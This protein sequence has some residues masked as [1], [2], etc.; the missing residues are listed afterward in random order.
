[1]KDRAEAFIFIIWNKASNKKDLII[2]DL[3]SRFEIISVYNVFWSDRYFS[4]NMARFYGEKLPSVAF[5]EKY[6]G[7]GPLTLVVVKDHNPIY[8]KRD[9]TRGKQTVNINVFDA[10]ERYRSWTG[11]GDR[12]H[13]SNS[14]LETKR[15]IALF[16]GKGYKQFIGEHKGKWGGRKLRLK[17]DLTGARGWKNLEELFKIL[18]ETT[19]YVVLRNFETIFKNN[20]NKEHPDIDILTDNYEDVVSITN[21]KSV[22]NKK[23]RV[24]HK[25]KVGNGYNL[26]DFR[27]VGDNYYDRAWEMDILK[28]KVLSGEDL[29]I[30]RQNDY[31][32]SLLYHALIHK[33]SISEDYKSRFVTM[34]RDLGLKN[35]SYDLFGNRGSAFKILNNYMNKKGY[36]YVDPVDLSV[37]NYTKPFRKLPTVRRILF[38]KILRIKNDTKAK[39]DSK[40]RSHYLY[41]ITYLSLLRAKLILKL[42]RIKQILVGQRELRK[43]N[44]KALT[45]YLF[46]FNKF[47]AFLSSEYKFKDIKQSHILNWHHGSY[48][49]TAHSK[50]N[51]KIFIKTDLALKLVLNEVNAIKILRNNK[52]I[53]DNI[54]EIIN[55]D[56]ESKYPFIA[57]KFINGESLEYLVN[58]KE[59]LPNALFNKLIEIVE[60]L[61]QANIL[62]RDIL[63]DNFLIDR[64]ANNLKVYLID[65]SFCIG[66]KNTKD[67]FVDL[68]PTKKNLNILLGLGEEFKPDKLTWDDAYSLKRI[69]DKIRP[70]Y[71][72][73]YRRRYEDLIKLIGKVKY[74]ITKDLN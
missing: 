74:H 26:F 15:E 52:N 48:H 30:P 61:H 60:N 40:L 51:E 29:Y 21:S 68:K 12:V 45:W 14:L 34:G 70:E 41:V 71:R 20:I 57:F 8:T 37:N 55:Y 39:S 66:T 2:D 67:R 59:T 5:K 54:P 42:K 33:L 9:T 17:R 10:K 46:H 35:L 65:Y 62:H 58:K 13:A 1:M 19:N 24:H 16:F 72:K 50:S 31:F 73:K 56:S 69:I 44:I 47:K 53:K 43:E 18:N 23:F 11:G 64:R 3:S 6:V 27:Y 36:H 7:R 28:N 49:F 22:F 32:Y 38:N 25:V 4:Q 63:M